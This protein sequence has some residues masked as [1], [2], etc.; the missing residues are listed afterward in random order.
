M[1]VSN[2]VLGPKENTMGFDEKI[3]NIYTEFSDFDKVYDKLS[4]LLRKYPKKYRLLLG[5]RASFIKWDLISKRKLKRWA[6]E[7]QQCGM[8]HAFGCRNSNYWWTCGN[9]P[10]QEKV[11]IYCQKIYKM[12]AKDIKKHIFNLYMEEHKKWEK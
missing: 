8:C 9:C 5:M 2:L 4:A 11:G 12:S 6:Y 7:D 1:L 10:A 3:E